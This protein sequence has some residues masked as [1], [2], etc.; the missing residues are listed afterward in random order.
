MKQKIKKIGAVFV[1]IVLLPYIVTI[2]MNGKSMETNQ[3]GKNGY[4]K[5]EMKVGTKRFH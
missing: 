3:N 4:I 5:V 1:I 2:F